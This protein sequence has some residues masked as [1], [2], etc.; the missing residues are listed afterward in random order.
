MSQSVAQ[1]L[2]AAARKAGTGSFCLRHSH[3]RVTGT[4]GMPTNKDCLFMR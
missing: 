2:K 3:A 1:S 4:P